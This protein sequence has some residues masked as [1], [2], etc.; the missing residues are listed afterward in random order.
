MSKIAYDPVKD[1]FARI[2][3]RS[4]TLRRLFYFLLDIIFLRSWHI[5]RIMKEKGS[6]FDRNGE[7]KLL[8]AGSGFGQYDR[9]ALKSFSNV[10]VHS[11]DV[12][13]DYIEDNRSYFHNEI[14]NGRIS[15][16]EA[17]LLNFDKE[18]K[19]DMVICID[20]LEHIEED[21]R[22]MKNLCRCMKSGGLFI[23]HS[24]S[25]YSEED[26]DTDD[27]FVG[28]HART[29][30][31]KEEIDKKL[32]ES[33]L[34]PKKIHYTYGYFGH[35]AW[36]L[37]VKWPMILFNKVGLFATLPLLVYYPIVLP[38]SLVLNS[39]DLF[40]KNRK[41]NGIYAIAEKI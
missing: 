35:K 34:H 26:S 6:E 3:R 1:K 5:R 11:V 41:G 37:S 23:M 39:I 7:W 36:V 20:V 14:E 12:K 38:L 8:D 24:P 40:T 10:K 32:M 33:D 21:K 31:S 16:Y 17:D 9:F 2:V 30:Y 25:H 18:E 29:G 15:I 22:V 19:F 4:K 13:E 27:T 28:E